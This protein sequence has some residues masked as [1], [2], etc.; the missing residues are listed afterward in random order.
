MEGAVLAVTRIGDATADFVLSALYK[1][2][3]SVVRL[4]P[5]ADFPGSLLLSANFGDTGLSGQLSTPTRE[6]DLQGVRSVYWRKPTPYLPNIGAADVNEWWTAEQTRFGLGGVLATLP[7]AAYVNHP[8]RN[9]D[10]E[11][12]LTQLAVAAECGFAVPPTVITNSLDSARSFAEELGPVVYKPVAA[13]PYW[14]EEHV[15]L[16]VWTGEVDPQELDER[17]NAAAHLFQWRVD[18]IADLRITVVGRH[19]F[20]VRIDSGL[21]DWRTDYDQHRYT[22]VECP[23]GLAEALHSYMRRFGLVFAAFDFALDRQ[24]RAWFLEANTNG[25]WAFLDTA[26]VENV[27][28]ALADELQ[29]PRESV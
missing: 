6:L 12:K 21:L 28:H 20:T 24:E 22:P 17:V 5:G 14:N 25:Q 7:G 3:V 27:T 16:A 13:P 19:V 18:K 10:A 15:P 4:D 26:T 8:W 9:R 29:T 1:R 2:D 11:V 23:A